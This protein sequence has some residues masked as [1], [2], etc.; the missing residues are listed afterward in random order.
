MHKLLFVMLFICGTAYAGSGGHSPAAI[1]FCGQHLQAI[2]AMGKEEAS[3]DFEAWAP[4]STAEPAYIEMV[5]KMLELYDPADPSAAAMHCL[6]HMKG[7]T[8]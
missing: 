1:Q 5:R 6:K 2:G 8:T 3:K 7:K 4:T